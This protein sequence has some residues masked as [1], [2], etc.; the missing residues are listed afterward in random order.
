M[1][2]S[3]MSWLEKGEV[4]LEEGGKELIGLEDTLFLRLQEYPDLI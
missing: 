1:I 4:W 2:C 3:D